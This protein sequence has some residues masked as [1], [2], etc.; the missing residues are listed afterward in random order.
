M[1]WRAR[2][3]RMEDLDKRFLKDLYTSLKQLTEDERELLMEKYYYPDE[4][5][6]DKEMAEKTGLTL[7]QY[8]VKRSKI[9]AK[10]TVSN[11]IAE[12]EKRYN[13]KFEDSG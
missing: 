10:L 9:E 8:R 6:N 3:D 1:K 13:V 11:R 12:H 4:P 7:I 5:I 2:A